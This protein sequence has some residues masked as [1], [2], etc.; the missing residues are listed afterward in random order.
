V[1]LNPKAFELF[2]TA[3]EA[4]FVCRDNNLDEKA[5]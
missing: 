2:A 1:R 4:A 5:F 3:V